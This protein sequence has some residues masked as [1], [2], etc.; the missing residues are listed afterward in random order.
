MLRRII[1]MS[2]VLRH[3]LHSALLL[4]LKDDKSSSGEIWGVEETSSVELILCYW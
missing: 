4:Y 1:A 3:S 2:F